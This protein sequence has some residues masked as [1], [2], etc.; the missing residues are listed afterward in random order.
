MFVIFN[1]QRDTEEDID[2]DLPYP[3]SMGIC[4]IGTAALVFA[5][6][7]FVLS[8]FHLAVFAFWAAIPLLMLGCLKAGF[9]LIVTLY[10]I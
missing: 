2:V 8:M 10:K 5:A 6:G 3:V 7:T 1:F 4:V 9:A